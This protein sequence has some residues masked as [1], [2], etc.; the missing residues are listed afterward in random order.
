MWKLARCT[1]GLSSGLRDSRADGINT[2]RQWF[3]FQRGASVEIAAQGIRIRIRIKIIKLTAGFRHVAKRGGL[4]YLAIKGV[5]CD[6][7]RGQRICRSLAGSL[8]LS[9]P[10]R[11]IPYLIH[12]IISL[13]EQCL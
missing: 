13:V 11:K 10:S 12:E 8:A 4:S 1:V 2:T 6:K 9:G 3:P 7:C 5:L